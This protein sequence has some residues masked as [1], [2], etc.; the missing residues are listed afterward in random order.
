VKVP[1]VLITSGEPAGIGPELVAQIAQQVW[2]VELSV[3]GDQELLLSR[4]KKIN[5][6]LHLIPFNEQEEACPLPAGSLKF[7]P[8]QL[9][10]TCEPGKLNP[11]NAAYV[12]ET[13]EKAGRLALNKTV[14]ALI[15]APVQ[16]SILNEA[17]ISFQGHTE[18]FAAQAS[19]KKALMLFVV[20]SPANIQCKADTLK[21]A[22]AT[23]HLPLAQVS[24]ALTAPV[25]EE[26]LRL[27]HQSLITQFNLP[28]PAIFICGLNPHAGEGGHL[29]REEIEQMTPVIEKLQREKMNLQGP[30]SAD[31][32][33]TEKYLRQADAILAMYHDQA[34]PVVKCL[35]FGQAV[36][37]TLGLPYVRT[38]VDHGTALDVAGTAQA[39]AGSLRAAVKLAIK[40]V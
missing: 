1:R 20:K 32:L 2:P 15:T 9:A 16:K 31:T 25:L 14:D 29:G 21:V 36:N 26:S 13:L 33:F 3:I 11:R 34:L 27:L 35:G 23:T 38:S 19:L 40:L 37:V 7:I 10:Q 22:L 24:Q 30:L 28:N 12:L 8:C 6:P 17:G 5:L 39:D 18:F 4:A